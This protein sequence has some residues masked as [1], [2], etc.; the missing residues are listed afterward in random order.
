MLFFAEK[1]LILK[2]SQMAFYM[3]YGVSVFSLGK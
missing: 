2:F 1:S 3:L